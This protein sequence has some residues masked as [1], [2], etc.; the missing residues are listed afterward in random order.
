MK[1]RIKRLLELQQLL[2]QLSKIDRMVHRQHGND[3]RPE[4]DTEHSYNL[5]MTAWYLSQWFPDLNKDLLIHYALVRDMVE[6]YAG[7]TF[8]YGSKDIKISQKKREYDAITRLNSEWQD[9]PDMLNSICN[10]EELETSESKFIY[11]LDKIMPI[12]LNYINDGY[13]WKKED[14][15]I[16]MLN[17]AKLNKVEISP[18]LLPYYKELYDLLL[19]RPDL[20]KPI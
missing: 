4:N 3:F 18:E 7:D 17:D 6:I 8:I 5:A 15:S 11:A 14:I 20:I 10:Y 1:P 9:F 19:S 13:S 2:S 12:M 16:I